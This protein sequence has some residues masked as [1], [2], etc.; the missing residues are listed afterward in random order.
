MTHIHNHPFLFD[1]KV[2]DR[3]WTLATTKEDVAGALAPSMTDVQFYRSMR[4][5]LG[6]EEA[7]VTNGLNSSRFRAGEFDLLTAR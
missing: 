6:L 5:S 7:W 1:R 3:M 2:G 4:A